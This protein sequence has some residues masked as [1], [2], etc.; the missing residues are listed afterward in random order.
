MGNKRIVGKTLDLSEKEMLVGKIFDLQVKQRH[1]GRILDFW[2]KQMLE[3]KI[4][5]T[6]G[7][8]SYA[9]ISLDKQNRSLP[10]SHTFTRFL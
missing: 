4:L 1:V 8:I 2:V 10:T 5:L 6:Y 3:D 7:S 9:V